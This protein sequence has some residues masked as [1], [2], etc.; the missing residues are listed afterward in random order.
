MEITMLF[1]PMEEFSK[2]FPATK[3]K[4]LLKAGILIASIGLSFGFQDA[5][6]KDDSTEYANY[7]ITSEA[8]NQLMLFDENTGKFKKVVYSISKPGASENGFDG[9]IFIPSAETGDIYRFDGYSGAF[10][11]IFVHKGDGGLVNPVSPNFGPDHLMYVSDDV[12]NKVLR[13]DANGKFVDV[14]ADK[15]SSGLDEPKMSEFDATTYYLASAGT[16]SILRWD[17]KTKKFLGAFVPTGSGGLARPLGIKFGPDGNFYV[18]SNK[19]N[20]IIRYNG[21]TGEFMDVFVPSG[22]GGVNDPVTVRFGGP[23]SNLYIVARGGN[24]VLEF[25]RITGKFIR[26]VSDGD[27]SGLSRARGLA[28]TTRPIFRLSA[29]VIGNGYYQGGHEIKH[30]FV[31]RLLRDDSDEAPEVK[32]ISVAS[33]DEKV[34]INKAVSHIRNGKDDYWFDLDFN[35]DSG[36]EQRYTFTYSASNSHGLSTIATTEVRVPPR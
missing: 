24:K 18:G 33:S 30:V 8:T 1:R 25:D 19:N 22:Y 11:G 27:S 7:F 28:F 15:E 12:T 16:N 6:A 21:K 36:V 14:F 31:D 17:L 3:K 32:L 10:K 9:D 5:S 34:D 35:N 20:S 13:F 4:S 26:V 29:Q 23:N 2:L